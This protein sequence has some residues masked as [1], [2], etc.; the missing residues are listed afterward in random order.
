MCKPDMN[1]CMWTQGCNFLLNMFQLVLS[2][3]YS[4]FSGFIRCSEIT[5][6]GI[7]L[8]LRS[9]VPDYLAPSFQFWAQ[10]FSV[11]NILTP[12]HSCFVR[13]MQQNISD[14]MSFPTLCGDLKKKKEYYQNIMQSMDLEL[15]PFIDKVVNFWHLSLKLLIIIHFILS[16][17]WVGGFLNAHGYS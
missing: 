6:C 3:P 12:T 1:V 16:I 2:D 10:K 4:V 13:E 8:S 9:K 15:F 7:L 17:V 14:N 11:H 5:C